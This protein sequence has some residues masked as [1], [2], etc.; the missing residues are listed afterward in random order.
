MLNLL[1]VLLQH[2]LNAVSLCS[3]ARHPLARPLHPKPSLTMCRPNL[4]QLLLDS[5]NLSGGVTAGRVV[6]Q[7]MIQAKVTLTE[8]CVLRRQQVKPASELS[9]MTTLGA[10]F[11]DLPTGCLVVAQKM[12]TSELGAPPS[13]PLSLAQLTVRR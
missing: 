2:F 11:F 13:D 6:T 7:L 1:P 4:L 3:R 10:T 9:P 8:L 12:C 5:L